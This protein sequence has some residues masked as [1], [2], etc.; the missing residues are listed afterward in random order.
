MIVFLTKLFVPLLLT[1]GAVS[2]GAA[3]GSAQVTDIPAFVA[4][5]FDPAAVQLDGTE[6]FSAGLFGSADCPTG[7]PTLLETLS[8]FWSVANSTQ[9]LDIF[10]GFSG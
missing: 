6:S 4:S 2:A 3:A 10:P 9:T 8:T 1:R 7:S 5:S